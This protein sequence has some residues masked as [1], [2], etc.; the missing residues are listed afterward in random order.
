MLNITVPR[1]GSNVSTAKDVIVSLLAREHPLKAKQVHER[2]KRE[3]GVSVSYQAV[4]KAL[5]ELFEKVFMKPAK[6]TIIV[7][8]NKLLAEQLREETLAYFK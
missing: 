6:I 4:H 8:R 7:T 1:I 2:L 3:L 5:G